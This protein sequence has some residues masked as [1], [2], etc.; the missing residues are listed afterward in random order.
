MRTNTRRVAERVYTDEGAPAKNI[1]VQAQLR[2][3]VMATMLFEGSFYEDGE[4]VANRIKKLIPK[5]G[6]KYVADLA[7]EARGAGCLRHVPLWLAREATR[8]YQGAAVGDLIA[9]VIQRADEIPEFVAIYM[10]GSASR[11][12]PLSAQA[13]RGLALAFDKFDEYQFQK[14][15]RKHSAWRLRDVLFL[16][17]PRTSDKKRRKLYKR[18]ANDKMKVAKTWET[19]LSGA[20]QKAQTEAEK[21]KAKR[22]LFTKMLNE[23]SLGYLALLRNLRGMLDV[24]VDEKLIR[25]AI[26]ARVGADR[27]LPFRFVAA[28]K[29]APRLEPVLDEALC[30]NIEAMP[31]L[32]GSTVVLVDVS[33]SMTW[34]RVSEKSELTHMDAAATLASVIN[35]ED[36]RVFTFSNRLVEVPPRRGM[37]GVEAICRSQDNGGTA[38][39]R[40]LNE[41]Q[42][43]ADF[44]RLIVITDEQSDD[45]VPVPKAPLAYMI[46]VANSRNGIGYGAWTHID[47]FS[48]SVLRF[49]HEVE[50]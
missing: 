1:S 31:M 47:G 8:H 38:L 21:A 20:G 17:R 15:D 3:S 28:A 39:G 10:E 32:R 44:D 30:H 48:E 29:H 33:A 23:S 6:L 5:V 49:I 34:N 19:S 50:S 22:K 40:A 36:L 27:V 11:N 45:V 43:S 7:R 12:A 9:D 26:L 16:V 46:N 24:N 14:W 41:L 25:E 2:R 13:K 37:A 4:A 18:I 42:A 35:A